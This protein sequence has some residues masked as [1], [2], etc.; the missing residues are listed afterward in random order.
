MRRWLLTAAALGL[1]ASSVSYALLFAAA[2]SHLAVR[3][4]AVLIWPTGL[5]LLANEGATTSAEVVGNFVKAIC[6]NVALYAAVGAL[7]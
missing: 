1:L 2:S 4:F 3:L 7:L 6:G 5:L